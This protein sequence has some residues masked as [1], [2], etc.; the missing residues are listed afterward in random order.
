MGRCLSVVWWAAPC[1]RPGFEPAKHWAACSGARELNH[2][3]TGPAPSVILFFSLHSGSIFLEISSSDLLI[4]L[5]FLSS[6]FYWLLTLFVSNAPFYS[7]LLLFTSRMQY[8]AFVK[9]KTIIFWSFL[10]LAYFSIPRLHFLLCLSESPAFRLKVFLKCLGI[11]DFPL[12]AKHAAP[13]TDLK[14]WAPEQGMQKW[15][16]R[17]QPDGVVVKFVCSAS[18]AQVRRFESQVHT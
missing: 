7:N 12:I 10:T 1:P 3:A 17:R 15:N 18:A 16:R 11:H 5:L 8:F 13:Q 4:V 14:I 6:L 9:I 2:S